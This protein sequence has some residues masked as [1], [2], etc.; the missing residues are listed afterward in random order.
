MAWF[1]SGR[2]MSGKPGSTPPNG[3]YEYLV[4]P[5]GL[6]NLPAVFQTMIKDVLRD[7][8]DHF[9]YVYSDDVLIYSPR[10]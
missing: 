7:F 3:H 2:G 4:M 5:F 9:V 10:S 8:L 1:G 6:T